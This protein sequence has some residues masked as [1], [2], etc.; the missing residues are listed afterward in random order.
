[1]KFSI[2]MPVYNAAR[3]LREAIDSVLAETHRKFE[4]ICMN[5]GA[6]AWRGEIFD[7]SALRES[8]WILILR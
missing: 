7:E 4:F 1:M 3:Y 8:H 5:E 6:T 2:T